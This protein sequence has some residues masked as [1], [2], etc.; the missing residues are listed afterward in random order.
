MFFLTEDDSAVMAAPVT[1]VGTGLHIGTPGRLFQAPFMSSGAY[2]AWD[3]R[4]LFA[5]EQGILQ[6][7]PLTLVEN[8]PVLTT[9]TGAR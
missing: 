9:R 4:F 3:G 1:Y 2:D 5:S 7:S 8:W 6:R